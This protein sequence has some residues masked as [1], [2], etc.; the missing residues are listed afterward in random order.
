MT[1]FLENTLIKLLV[2]RPA[3]LL[4]PG[5]WDQHSATLQGLAERTKHPQI[6]HAVKRLD[7]RNRRQQQSSR[8][9]P[10]AAMTPAAQVYLI[11][12]KVDYSKMVRIEEVST[13]CMEVISNPVN[14]VSVLLQ[15]ASS[16]YR[17]GLYRACL[18]TRLLRRWAHLG[19]DIYECITTYLEDMGWTRIGDARKVF[20]IISE[21]V[22]SKTF[23]AGRYMQWLIATGSI[24]QNLDLSQVRS[25]IRHIMFKAHRRPARSV[26]D[27]P[28]HRDPYQWVIGTSPHIACNTAPWDSTLCGL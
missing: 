5:T 13:D 26:A 2:I 27:T 24:A 4:L 23:A 20:K 3:C 15:W 7:E 10:A 8:I 17:E 18:A 6:V 14:L 22:R 28:D 25:I 1:H 21:L 19:A 9:A 16:S 11:L 12:D